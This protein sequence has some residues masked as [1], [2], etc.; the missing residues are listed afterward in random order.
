MESSNLTEFFLIINDYLR[1]DK[2]QNKEVLKYL[3]PEEL[4][5]VI[6]FDIKQDGDDINKILDF[7]KT[8]LIYN[9]K[10]DSK[11]FF[12]QLYG[13][14][15]LPAF[16][17]EVLTTIT[18]TAGHTYEAAPIAMII[19]KMLIDK[20]SKLLGYKNGDGIFVPG[21]SNSNMIGMFSARNN[22]NFDIK[23][24]GIYNLPVLKAFVSDQA[25]YSH[26]NAAN[27]LGIGNDNL[28]KIKSSKNGKMIPEELEKKILE[29]KEQGVL[30]FYV[31]A[32][33]A[34]TMLSAIDP[35]KEISEIAKNHK[36]W[37]HVDAALGGSFSLSRKHKHLLSGIEHADSITWN[38][39]KLMNSPLV[40]SVILTKE[41]GILKKNLTRLSSQYLFHG[42]SE[43][44]L[45]EKSLQCARRI[46]S[47]K[48]FTAWK[49]HGDN[50]YEK[51][52]NSLFEIAEYVEQKVKEHSKLELQV[53]RQT[54]SVCF[55]YLSDNK[56]NINTFNI[57][58]RE[59]LR[60]KGKSLVNYGYIGEDVTIRFIN[61]NPDVSLEDIDIFFDSFIEEALSLEQKISLT[62]V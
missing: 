19:E 46:D 3:K 47:V 25:H 20:M 60:E 49:F 33:A 17:G 4:K 21:G 16:F 36:M 8:Y 18:N 56:K 35:L 42:N 23:N 15:N 6:D 45:G 41:K 10:T 51:R 39:H 50:G 29:A 55:R 43:Y 27:L 26:E 52:I 30:P 14:N 61:V 48:L 44:N 12:N 31:A 11:Q 57:K 38:P 5:K 53:N 34:T 54:L 58:L 32:T 2:Q 59:S 1:K 37:F 40:T 9:V 22:L 28:I 13:G 7:I 24:K 62:K